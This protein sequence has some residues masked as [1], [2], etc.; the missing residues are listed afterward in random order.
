MDPPNPISTPPTPKE[1]SQAASKPEGDTNPGS[2]ED[3]HRKCRDLFPICFEG[4]KVMAMKPLS[5]H[6]Q[7]LQSYLL[8]YR[9]IAV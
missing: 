9:F 3:L 8:N 4:A 2:F 7:V 5:S 6:F 1:N